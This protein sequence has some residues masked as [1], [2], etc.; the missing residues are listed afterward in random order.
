[1]K[2]VK[3]YYILTVIIA[4]FSV[5]V[6]GQ[7][8]L[9]E[10]DQSAVADFNKRVKAY[11]A[12]RE[13][14]EEGLP[15]LPKDATPEQI[16]AHKAVFQK[17]V[18]KARAAAK[19]GDVITPEAERALRF[20]IT[21]AYVGDDRKRLRETIFEAENKSVPVAVNAAYPEAVEILEMPPPLLLALPE[22]P[23]QLRY[24]FV[25]GSLLLMDRENHLIVDFMTNAVPL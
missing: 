24:R 3:D 4:V 23:K 8:A 9:S 15:K 17:A 19:R 6:A 12:M 21:T 11:V 14:I 1:M 5:S 10:A 22:L 25:A 20:I 7:K 18:Q 16:E 2:C 13:K